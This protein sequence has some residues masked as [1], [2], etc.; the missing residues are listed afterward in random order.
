MFG[1]DFTQ[2]CVVTLER[3]GDAAFASNDHDKA[4][5]H[6]ALALLH[7][8]TPPKTTLKKWINAKLT[9]RN[10]WR[11]VLKGPLEVCFVQRYYHLLMT[12]V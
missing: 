4:T 1:L 9:S 2:R 12:A 8:Q 11:E 5:M 6:Y 3:T 7:C 10:S